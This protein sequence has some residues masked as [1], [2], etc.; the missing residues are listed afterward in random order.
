MNGV[1]P[2]TIAGAYLPLRRHYWYARGKLVSDPLYAAVG[3]ALRDTRAPLLDLGCGIGLLAQ[4]LRAQGY[5]G[6]YFGVDNDATKIDA[7]RSAAEHANLAEV[8]FEC[9]DLAREPFPEHQGSVTLLDVLQFVPEP[10]ATQLIER[11]AACLVPGARLVIRSGL[12]SANARTR[13]TR[14]I[15]VLSRNVGWMNASPKHYPTRA[16]LEAA[17]ARCGLRAR[18]TSLNGRLPFNNWLI[19]AERG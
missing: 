18:F 9:V 5:C 19:V 17:L 15:D 3:G 4:M 8:R 10:A 13:F 16:G 2:H 11:A 6:S 14:A 7:A 12:E 1:R